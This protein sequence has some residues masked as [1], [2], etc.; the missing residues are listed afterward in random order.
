MK[1]KDYTLYQ[2]SEI[3][4]D[5]YYLLNP[6]GDERDFSFESWRDFE[7]KTGINP[8]ADIEDTSLDS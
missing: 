1:V 7:R 4:R 2:I 8:D 5:Q 6:L 3:I